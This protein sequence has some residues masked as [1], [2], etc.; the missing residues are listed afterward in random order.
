MNAQTLPTPPPPTP[1]HTQTHLE[2]HSFSFSGGPSTS[3]M[4]MFRNNQRN[5]LFIF[6]QTL[7]CCAVNSPI[8]IE[9]SVYRSIAAVICARYPR[10]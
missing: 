1:L 8:A 7:L 3:L 10:F 5:L 4:L 6:V 2:K 9:G